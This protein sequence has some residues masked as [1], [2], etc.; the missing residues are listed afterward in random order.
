M[1]Y[2]KFIIIFAVLSITGC[3]QLPCKCDEKSIGYA[4]PGTNTVIVD[5]SLNAD[6]VPQQN[7]EK[8]IVKPGQDVIFS[9]PDEFQI[10]FKNQKT[11]NT[12]IENKSSSGIVLIQVPVD[13]LEKKEFSEEFRRY[14]Y[15]TFDYAIRVNGRELDPPMVVKRDF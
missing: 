6:G 15:L 11:P 5:V 13:V 4:L 1:R 14:N 8:I 12:V 7:Y 3:A 10:I 2:L 9:G